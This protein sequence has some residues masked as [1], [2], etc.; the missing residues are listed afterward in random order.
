MDWK[1]QTLS[2]AGARLNKPLNDSA[3]P[4]FSKVP[5]HVRTTQKTSPPRAPSEPQ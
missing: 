1:N 3:A 5:G 2:I 4:A